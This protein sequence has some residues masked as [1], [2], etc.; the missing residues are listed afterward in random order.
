MKI[1]E[2]KGEEPTHEVDGRAHQ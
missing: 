1:D 2:I